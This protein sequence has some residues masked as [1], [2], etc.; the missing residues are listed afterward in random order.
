MVAA[1]T[2]EVVEIGFL[3][4]GHTHEDID[5]SFSVLSRHLKKNQA[6]SFSSYR[7]EVTAAYQNQL[8]CPK[9]EYVHVKRDYKKWL[10]QPGVLIPPAERVGMFYMSL[11][12]KNVTI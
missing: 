11:H 3:P 10:E 8:D 4:V 5:Q 7:R 12:G 1:G 6:M 9:L 2:F